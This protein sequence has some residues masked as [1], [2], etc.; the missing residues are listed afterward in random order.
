M[1][2]CASNRTNSERGVALLISI[3]ALLLI[4]GV[5]ISLIVMA[6]TETS[7]NANYRRS[8][9][10]FYAAQAGLEEARERLVCNSPNTLR[11]LDINGKCEAANAN[12]IFPDPAGVVPGQVIY[13]V[14]PMAG[15]AAFDPQANPT[16]KYYDSE[17]EDEFAVPPVANP[18]QKVASSAMATAQN[19]PPLFYKWVRITLKSEAMGGIDLDGGGLDSNLALRAQGNDNQCVPGM[20]GCTSDPNL[21]VTTNAVYRITAFALDPTGARRLVQAE[22]AEMPTVNPNGA[23]ASQAGVT[24]NGNFNAFGAWPPIVNKTCGSGKSSAEIPTC[25][26][27]EGGKVV[28]DCNKPYNPTT[29]MC[30][31]EPRPLKDYCNVGNPVDGVTSQ[32]AIVSG[33]YSQVPE[34]G[35]SCDPQKPGCIFTASPQQALRPNVTDWPYDMDQIMDFYRPPVTQPIG[36]FPSVTCDT[37]DAD[38]NR[39]CKGQDSKL[40]TLPDPWPVPPNVPEPT[41]EPKLVYADVGR[42]GLLKLTGG[43]SGAGI[44]V[45]E[46]DLEIQAGFQWYGLIVVRGVVT[47]LGGGN[48]PTNIIGGILA[49]KSVT[50]A[51]TTAGGSVSITY[52]SCA[53]RRFGQDAPLRYLS[54]REIAH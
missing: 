48:T 11:K 16:S 26:S 47:F 21:P 10:A 18:A 38:G 22:V 34:S 33:N 35:S 39:T 36:D 46:G 31:T 32:E 23:I 44:L 24:I 9:T 37:V 25:G 29:D 45:V 20:A 27:Y 50:D 30:G 2:A 8:V 19:M 43:S 49:G 1:S 12:P 7:L 54:F 14:N 42:E 28:G 4:S 5:A 17:Y 6:G 3:F 52:S 41:Y 53:Y 15:E 40:G 13:I 51:T